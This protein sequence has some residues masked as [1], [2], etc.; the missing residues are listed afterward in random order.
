MML[1]MVNVAGGINGLSPHPER[2]VKNGEIC[3]K[4]LR[5]VSPREGKFHGLDNQQG[6]R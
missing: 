1:G 3:W 2:V 6:K 5:A 4:L